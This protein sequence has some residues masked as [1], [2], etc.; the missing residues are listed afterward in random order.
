MPLAAIGCNQKEPAVTF[1]GGSLRV[2]YLVRVSSSADSAG[3]PFQD[4]QQD[5]GG[6][7]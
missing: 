1:A 4:E 5:R 2:R 3:E 6:E 7:R